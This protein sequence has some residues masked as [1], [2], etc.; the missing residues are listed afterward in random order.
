MSNKD[1]TKNELRKILHGI[2][3]RSNQIQEY[4]ESKGG[5]NIKIPPNMDSRFDNGKCLILSMQDVR[6]IIGCIK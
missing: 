4:N 5:F 2:T 6:D 1:E 3:I